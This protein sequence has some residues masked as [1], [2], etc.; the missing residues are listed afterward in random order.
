MT[1][2]L[3]RGNTFPVNWWCVWA[4]F[5]FDF[6]FLCFPDIRA[7]TTKRIIKTRR[8]VSLNVADNFILDENFKDFLEHLTQLCALG[9]TM[10]WVGGRKKNQNASIVVLWTWV[11]KRGGIQSQILICKNFFWKISNGA[12]G[13]GGDVRCHSTICEIAGFS[14]G[15]CL[16]S[17]VSPY[18]SCSPK[19]D[20]KR[21][22]VPSLLW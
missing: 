15:F 11:Q 3:T 6:G 10:D 4:C 8:S 13:R 12:L 22:S 7:S 21:T 16:F 18:E 17:I 1:R 20:R 19:S 14:H 5:S 9:V 2:L